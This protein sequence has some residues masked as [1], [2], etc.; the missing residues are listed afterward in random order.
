MFQCEEQWFVTPWGHAGPL[1]NFLEVLFLA[2]YHGS[3]D[4]Q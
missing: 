1:S 2:S 4:H 3:D